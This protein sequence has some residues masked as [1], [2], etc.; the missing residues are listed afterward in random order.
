VRPAG[1]ERRSADRVNRLPYLPAHLALLSS[2]AVRPAAAELAR[3]TVISRSRPGER[4]A[5]RVPSL[6]GRGM[7]GR[8]RGDCLPGPSWLAASSALSESAAGHEH[9]C[10]RVTGPGVE[11]PRR[12]P[13]RHEGRRE[14]IEWLEEYQRDLEERAAE[15]AE[16]RRLRERARPV[17]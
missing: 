14:R 11:G 12:R 1:R 4:T 5:K 16:I 15:V 10:G 9:S 13:P 17:A 7:P 2:T 3:G 8:R 6:M